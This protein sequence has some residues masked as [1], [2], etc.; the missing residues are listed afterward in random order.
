MKDNSKPPLT[1]PEVI[2]RSSVQVFMANPVDMRPVGFGSGCILEHR[3]RYFFVS[4]RHVTDYE[5]LTTFLETGIRSEEEGKPGY[6]LQPI[7]GLYTFDLLKNTAAA[8]VKHF[9][10][11]IKKGEKLDITFAEIKQ[12]FELRQPAMDFG[13]FK[14]EE[15]HKMILDTRDIA[16]PSKDKSYAFFGRVKIQP[17]R[18]HIPMENT[19][20]H[21]LK[22]H[23]VFKQ[24]YQFNA[25]EVILD[26]KDY[27]GCSGAPIIDSDGLLVA[28]ACK[29]V[30]G[31]T[32]V[33][34]FSIHECI[35]LLD[36]AIKHEVFLEQ[37]KALDQALENK[38]DEG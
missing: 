20:K 38:K 28:L 3:D 22:F 30:Q 4:V 15:G 12:N 10:D 32:L 6:M 35:K 34:G 27:Q 2:V 17:G 7:G 8:S 29:V 31:A 26:K 19:V 25:T 14:I 23:G 37:E 21:G 24:F 1:V 9:E 33:L 11:L 16:E 18:L 13:A 5:G 36:Y